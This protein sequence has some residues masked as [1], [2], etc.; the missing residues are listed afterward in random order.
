MTI[1]VNGKDLNFQDSI[2]VIELLKHQKVKMPD[3]VTVQLND[4]IIPKEEFGTIVVKDNDIVEFLY[5]MGGG[6]S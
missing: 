4:K 3:Y 5:F 1:K 2:T 6:I